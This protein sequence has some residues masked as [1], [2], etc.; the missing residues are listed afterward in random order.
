MRATSFQLAESGVFGTLTE[1]RE[2][3]AMMVLVRM[4]DLVMRARK[5][6]QERKEREEEQKSKSNSYD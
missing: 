5:E 3:E 6:E 1:L 4:Y 2:S